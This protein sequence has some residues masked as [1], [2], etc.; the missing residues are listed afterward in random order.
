[1]A[2]FLNTDLFKSLNVGVALDEGLANPTD[3]FTVFYG[4]RAVWWLRVTAEGPTGHGR[5]MHH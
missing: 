5:Y 2:L 1:M 4:E 3:K